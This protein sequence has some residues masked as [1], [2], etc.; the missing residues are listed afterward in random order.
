MLFRSNTMVFSMTVICLM[1]FMTI[2]VLSCG[3]SVNQSMTAEFEAMT[4][5]DVCM[6]K[7]MEADERQ[8][9]EDAGKGIEEYLLGKGLALGEVLREGYTE[10]TSYVLPGLTWESTLG[11]SKEQVMEQ[12]PMLD[13]SQREEFVPLSAYNRMAECFGIRSEER[14]VGKECT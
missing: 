10:V 6:T 2:G 3:V 5:R 8:S 1:L 12:F 14:R 11:A 13:W 9:F 7:G 4:P